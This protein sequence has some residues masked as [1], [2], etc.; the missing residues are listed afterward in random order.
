MSVFHPLR[1]LGFGKCQD[2][3]IKLMRVEA[4]ATRQ[5]VACIELMLERRLAEDLPSA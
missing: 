5:F 4:I 3:P 1:T 2:T